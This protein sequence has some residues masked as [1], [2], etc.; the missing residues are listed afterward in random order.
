MSQKLFHGRFCVLIDRLLV[1]YLSMV[2]HEIYREL[3][4]RIVHGELV[5]GDWLREDA[6]ATE[7]GVSRTPVRE[8]LRQLAQDGLAENIRK[9]GYCVLGFTVDD[10]EEAYEIRRVL[11]LLALDR[12][13]KTLPI[14]EL[15]EIRDRMQAISNSDDPFEHARIDSELHQLI[16]DSS[17][18]RRLVDTLSSL[19]RIMRSF[20]E[21]GYE[22]S[23]VRALAM[24]E[25]FDLMAAL[26][27][28][29]GERAAEVLDVHI[30]AS[31]A[32]V[33]ERV[34]GGAFSR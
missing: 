12:A 34:L 3:F 11:E 16:V 13:V 19:Y 26:A 18:S 24:Q 31:K 14:R 1:Y 25:H 6:I 29:D 2:G 28:R 32:R 10:L 27:S 30:R 15:K 8:S 4:N 22:A 21:L 17:R 7:F 9:R 23:E 5:A 20:R 33:L